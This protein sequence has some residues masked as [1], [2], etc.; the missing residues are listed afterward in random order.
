MCDIHCLVSGSSYPVSGIWLFSVHSYATFTVWYVIVV[1]PVS[2]IWI[3]R[4][5]KCVIFTVWYVI[6]SVIL[7]S[8]QYLVIRCTQLCDIHCMVCDC[9]GCIASVWL[10]D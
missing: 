10:L 6:I 9:L 8:V 2:G 7:S 5:H 3:F 4:I 1:Y